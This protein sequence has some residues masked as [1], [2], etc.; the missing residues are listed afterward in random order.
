MKQDVSESL[1]VSRLELLSRASTYGVLAAWAAFQQSLE[2]TVLTW[3]YAH[4]GSQVACRLRSEQHFVVL[5]FERL[6]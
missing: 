3:L 6:R 4:P 2:E 1:E 5:T